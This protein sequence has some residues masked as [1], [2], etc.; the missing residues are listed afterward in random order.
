MRVTKRQPIPPI[1]GT[2]EQ[3]LEL[4]RQALNLLE[5]SVNEIID[6]V[7]ANEGV[8]YLTDTAPAVD[9]SMLGRLILVH[10]SGGGAD[11]LYIC[12]WNGSAYTLQPINLP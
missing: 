4:M 8:A 7:N 1:V 5:R 12:V 9:A 3:K 10:P 2:P 11:S 6:A